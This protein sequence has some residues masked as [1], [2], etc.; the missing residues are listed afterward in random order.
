MIVV[1]LVYNNHTTPFHKGWTLQYMEPKGCCKIVVHLVYNNH[2]PK[3]NNK[4]SVFYRLLVVLVVGIFSVCQCFLIRSC[5][6]KHRYLPGSFLFQK[7]K[8]TISE[9]KGPRVITWKLAPTLVRWKCQYPFYGALAFV[10][11]NLSFLPLIKNELPVFIYFF[12]F[13]FFFFFLIF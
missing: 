4:H 8:N 1:H 9:R 6:L 3:D 10:H 12:F 13:F 2:S 5:P 7:I 11:P